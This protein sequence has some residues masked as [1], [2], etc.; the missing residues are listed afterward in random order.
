MFVSYHDLEGV[1]LSG[2]AERVSGVDQMIDEAHTSRTFGHARAWSIVN[3][4]VDVVAASS[5][6][7][8]ISVEIRGTAR[9]RAAG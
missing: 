9:H 7:V 8:G 1:P 3:H 4:A 2:R 6:S 5:K